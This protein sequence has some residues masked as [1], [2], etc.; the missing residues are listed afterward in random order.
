MSQAKL[1][2]APYDNIQI[3]SLNDVRSHGREI[4]HWRTARHLGQLLYRGVFGHSVG[5]ALVPV[6]NTTHIN[7]RGV[8]ARFEM[9]R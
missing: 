6:A 4:D 2:L 9:V 5:R 7:S 1:K 8:D 3:A